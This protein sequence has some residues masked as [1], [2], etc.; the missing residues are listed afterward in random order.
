M[1]KDPEAISCILTKNSLPTCFHSFISIQSIQLSGLKKIMWYYSIIIIYV[2]MHLLS[3]KIARTY[4][5][6]HF[7]W[8]YIKKFQRLP[9]PS[10]SYE[11]FFSLCVSIFLFFSVATKDCKTMQRYESR[12]PWLYSRLTRWLNALEKRLFPPPLLLQVNKPQKIFLTSI[13]QKTNCS[14]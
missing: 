8:S 3:K 5:Y 14:N 9:F 13:P 10:V 7:Q 4:F 2:E 1:K 11:L 12:C 6:I